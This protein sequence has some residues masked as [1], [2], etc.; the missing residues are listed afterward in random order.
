[1]AEYK[2]LTTAEAAELQKQYGFN[3]SEEKKLPQFWIF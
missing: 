1:M 3:E 2:G